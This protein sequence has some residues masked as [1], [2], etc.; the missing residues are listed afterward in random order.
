MDTL[1]HRISNDGDPQTYGAFVRQ[2]REAKGLSVRRL[3]AKLEVTPVYLSDLERG[4][5]AA[6][7]RNSP[8]NLLERICELLIT[9]EEDEHRYYDLAA[10]SR[11]GQYDELNYYLQQ[12]ANARLALR[13][14]RDGGVTEDDWSL[15]AEQIRQR[16]TKE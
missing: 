12:H 7:R 8:K 4:N 2:K 9:T 5:R 6:P 3:A 1:Q 14:A 15:I 13:V 16:N 11:D 10:E